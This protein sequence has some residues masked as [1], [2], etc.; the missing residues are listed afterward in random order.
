MLRGPVFRWG[1]GSDA[2]QRMVTFD[3]LF[4]PS[5]SDHGAAVWAVDA[6]LDK[7][8]VELREEGPAL[9]Y[10]RGTAQLR[11]PD[12][13]PELRWTCACTPPR[14]TSRSDCPDA[15]DLVALERLREAAARVARRDGTGG[16]L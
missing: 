9:L 1:R 10:K 12:V 11:H 16:S 6:L 13:P 2:A 4:A 14:A 8:Y 5:A 3:E 15:L 7:G